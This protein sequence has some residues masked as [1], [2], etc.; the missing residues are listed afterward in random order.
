MDTL[1]KLDS[2]LFQH[3]KNITKAQGP[4]KLTKE[5]YETLRKAAWLADKTRIICE[6]NFT[7]WRLVTYHHNTPFAYIIERSDE[8]ITIYRVTKTG[9]SDS[10]W[11]YPVFPLSFNFLPIDLNFQNHG[12]YF[13]NGWPRK[14][15]NNGTSK[16]RWDFFFRPQE[17]YLTEPHEQYK[18][19]VKIESDHIQRRQD[20]IK[21]ILGFSGLSLILSLFYILGPDTGI[22]F[23]ILSLLCSL[24]SPI[25]Y[26]LLFSFIFLKPITD[27]STER[28]KNDTDTLF[29]LFTIILVLG[30]SFGFMLLATHFKI[31]QSTAISNLV[32][33]PAVAFFTSLI[34][35]K[36]NSNL[37]K[38]QEIIKTIDTE[39]EYLTSQLP[40]VSITPEELLEQTSRR[41]QE[42]EQPALDTLNI[43]PKNLLALPP[44]QNRLTSQSFSIIDWGGIQTLNRINESLIPTSFFAQINHQDENRRLHAINYIQLLFVTKNQV[45]SYSYFYNTITDSIASINTNEYYFSNIVSVSSKI[46]EWHDE[47]KPNTLMQKLTF[48][49]SVENGDAVEVSLLEN[50]EPPQTYGSQPSENQPLAGSQPSLTP[51]ILE[52]VTNAEM[53]IRFIRRQLKELKRKE[54]ALLAAPAGF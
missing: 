50:K 43:N 28:Q 45:I 47:S 33:I 37:K 39:I 19:K 12:Q 2:N 40:K 3:L 22:L 5:L 1:K 18:A 4:T 29:V 20:L 27:A 24:V 44:K 34:A 17:G 35:F 8:N 14:K 10:L 7:Q 42:S 23:K 31:H 52:G 54:P 41:I 38:K 49:L 51:A 53:A 30:V 6:V 9:Y 36:N 46:N 16:K 25:P 32:T 13:I 26:L 21:S 48:R 11:D 15:L